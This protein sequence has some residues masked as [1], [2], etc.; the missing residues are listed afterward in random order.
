MAQGM[1]WRG[2]E[3]LDE[4]GARPIYQNCKTN[5]PSRGLAIEEGSHSVL[6]PLNTSH[7]SIP[8][9]RTLNP[10]Q[11]V[12][13]TSPAGYTLTSASS[14]SP[15]CRIL[16]TI[17]PRASQRQWL[18]FIG[19]SN[20]RKLVPIFAKL[21]GLSSSNSYTPAGAKH[22]TSMVYWSDSLVLTFQW[23]YAQQADSPERESEESILVMLLQPSVHNWPDRRHW[24]ASGLN[25]FEAP[26]WTFISFGSHA[27]RVTAFGTSQMLDRVA[28]VILSAKAKTHLSISLTSAVDLRRI[29]S[30]YRDSKVLRNNVM[31]EATNQVIAQRAATWDVPVIDFFSVSRTCGP[32]M[33]IDVVHYKNE[34]YR[35]WADMIYTHVAE[36]LQW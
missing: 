13:Q 25:A 18:Y 1:D 12:C 3:I 29:P 26:S 33:Q 5:T 16:R 15:L 30:E 6:Q 35:I 9:C 4:S 10:A 31:L 14:A 28:P 21:L 11:G 27:P 17:P 19:D 2:K 20:T 34:V 22:P 23:F 8:V 24:E 36:T 7:S 32:D